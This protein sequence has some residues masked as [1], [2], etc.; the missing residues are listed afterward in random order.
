M[1]GHFSSSGPSGDVRLINT[2]GTGEV[3]IDYTSVADL[4]A[5]GCTICP[6]ASTGPGATDPAGLGPGL[7]YW[8][9]AASGR[10]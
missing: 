1:F 2:D 8:Q 4:T 3:Q 5:A 9:P 7:A 10:P 6:Y